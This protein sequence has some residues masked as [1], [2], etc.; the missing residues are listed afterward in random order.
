MTEPLSPRAAQ[1]VPELSADELGVPD[2]GAPRPTFMSADEI[3]MGL[4]DDE[5]QP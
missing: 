4:P 2:L 3:T 5:A 1:K